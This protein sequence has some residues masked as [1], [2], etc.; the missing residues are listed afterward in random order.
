MEKKITPY[1][2]SS[3]G[4]KRQVEQMFDAISEN[5][6]GLNRVISLGSDIKWRKKVI[7]MVAEKNPKTILDIATGTGDL[8]IQFAEK[9]SAKKIVGLD[10]SEGMLSVARKKVLGKKIS[11]K[12][13][14]VQ[15]DSEALPFED[16][17]FDAIT[18]S[19]GIRNFENLEKGLSEILRVLKNGGIFVILET[20]VPAKFPFKQ[21]YHLYSKT[22]L[23]L[24]GRM[25]SKDKVAYKYLSES[26]SVFPHGEKLNN[27]LRKIG[28]KEVKNKPQ[29]FGVATIYNATK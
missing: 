17:A 5:Y 25:F 4:K 11:E 22:I 16:N 19:F 29:T 13:E 15:A 24:V 14:F 7:K 18:V 27:I 26:A 1:K 21:G 28:F 8:A 20:S 12:I 3:E 6:D 10:L 2:D 23:P 9:T